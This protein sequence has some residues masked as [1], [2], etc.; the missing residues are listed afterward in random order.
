MTTHARL[1]YWLSRSIYA[2]NTLPFWGYLYDA[3]VLWQ[4]KQIEVTALKR[5]LLATN[6]T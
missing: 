4:N 6:V 3:R 5:S 1:R 2:N